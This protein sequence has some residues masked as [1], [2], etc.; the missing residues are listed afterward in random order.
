MKEQHTQE[1]AST[2]A[3]ILTE[4]QRQAVPDKLWDKSEVGNYLGVSANTLNK[5]MHQLPNPVILPTGGRRWIPKQ[6][7]EWAERRRNIAQ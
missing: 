7:R 5:F 3:M 1:T 6:I 2:V 4:L